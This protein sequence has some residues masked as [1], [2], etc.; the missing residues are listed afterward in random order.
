MA[1]PKDGEK[2]PFSHRL[3]I[4][5]NQPDLAFTLHPKADE[6]AAIARFAQLH[7]VHDF[8]IRYA[9][10]LRPPG[11][12]AVTGSFTAQI[13][14]ICVVSLEP[15]A[16][17]LEGDIDVAFAPPALAEKLSKEALAQGIEDFEPPDELTDG[18]IDL[19][20]L[21]VEFLILALDPYPRKPGAV[22]AGAAGEDADPSPFAALA[23]LK[24]RLGGAE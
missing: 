2:L 17:S 14:P 3:E 6:C 8:E 15:F 1:E 12:I 9:I 18:G 4:A 21:A 20:M 11:L 16:Q 5:Q 13:E 24:P 23:A 7:A 22:F 19:G 10:N